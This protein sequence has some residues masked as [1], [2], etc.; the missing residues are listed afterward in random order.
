M[1]ILLLGVALGVVAGLI[2]GVGV[3]TTLLLFYPVV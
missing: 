2:P 1:E 3:F